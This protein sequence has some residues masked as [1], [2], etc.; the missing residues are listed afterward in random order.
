MVKQRLEHREIGANMRPRPEPSLPQK[1][2]ELPT[3]TVEHVDEYLLKWK[4]L[5]DYNQQE[6]ALD[7]LFLI[8][9]P[10]N[11]NISDIL[12]KVCT[13]NK[14]YSTNILKINPVA[15]RILEQNIDER[16]QREDISL[17]DDIKKV[18]IQGKMRCFYSF[19]TKYCSHHKPLVYPIYDSNVD[20]VLRYYRRKDKFASFKNDDLKNYESFKSII[21]A[22]RK[23]YCLEKCNF[24]ELDKY[25]WQLGKD[26]FNGSSS[27]S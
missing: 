12:L 27:K 13:L 11:N 5:K 14:F 20:N 7:K 18:E 8:L 6:E 19:A 21:E 1:A 25:L 2:P 24:K 3:P 22:F 17:V 26:H 23:F 9:C 4:S 10:E 15:Q 16:L